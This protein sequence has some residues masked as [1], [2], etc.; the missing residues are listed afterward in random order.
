MT[1]LDTILEKTRQTVAARRRET[2]VSRLEVLPGFARTPRSLHAALR[3]DGLAFIAESKRRSPSK[4]LLRE[5][6]SAS[7]NARA[8]THA[9]AAALSVLTE[10]EF[11]GGAPGDLVAARGQTDLPILRKDFVVDEYQL[12]EARAWGAD[13]VL[14]IAAAL[15][16]AQLRHFQQVCHTLGM[17]A[18]VEVHEAAELDGLDWSLTR[19]VG[20]NNRD[21]RTFEVDTDRAPRVFAHIPEGVARVAESGL[22]D[23]ATIARLARA[24]TDAVL[25]GETFMRAP[26][27]GVALA[28]LR[29]DVQALLEHASAGSDD[30]M[31]PPH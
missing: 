17:D 1:I 31:A 16:P 6:Y 3:G 22:R 23:A 10:P 20:V 13:A 30:L 27:P 7:D 9:G 4:G 25:I 18:L 12:F 8:Y 24:G 5:P 14:L 2:P 28:T 26:N 29:Q 11:F 19:I 15:E 21:L